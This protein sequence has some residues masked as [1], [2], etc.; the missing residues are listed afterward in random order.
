M[1]GRTNT[2][3]G[4]SGGVKGAIIGVTYPEGASVSVTN[5]AKTYTAKDTDGNTAFSVEA[6]TW[7][8][9]ATLGEE[10]ASK[11]VTVAEGD[12]TSVELNFWDGTLFE[13][14]N[15]YDA[16]TGGWAARAWKAENAWNASAPTMSIVSDGSSDDGTMNI[17]QTGATLSGVV[18]VLKDV[19]LTEW[20][21]FNV[22]V[23]KVKS[24]GGLLS[25]AAVARDAA[26]FWTNAAANSESSN[27]IA[28]GILS[29]DISNV[30][31]SHDLVVGLKTGISSQSGTTN[32]YISK[33]WLE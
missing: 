10:S 23:S 26:L 7:E 17:K 12:F 21:S 28:T 29:V 19:D 9:R 18:E 27:P 22:E 14:G 15:S 24:S 16:Y 4:I 25:L 6:G 32:I 1:T 33:I 20:T 30:N 13:N 5:G 8:V 2:G 3:G 11:S 31:G